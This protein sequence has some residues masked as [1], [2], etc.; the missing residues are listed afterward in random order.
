MVISNPAIKLEWHI[1]CGRMEVEALI[2]LGHIK[3][4][5]V[6]YRQGL[7]LAIKYPNKKLYQ[8]P[9]GNEILYYDR[10][11]DPQRGQAGWIYATDSR[12]KE[13]SHW[14]IM[15]MFTN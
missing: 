14:M 2:E 1:V 3:P 8:G 13:I 9:W 15:K 5:R 11:D 12:S 10:F 6:D 4:L 7:F